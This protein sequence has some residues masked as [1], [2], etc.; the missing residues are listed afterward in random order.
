MPDQPFSEFDHAIIL[1]RS[2]EHGREGL[3]R[4]GFRPTPPGLHGAGLGTANV[5]VMMP[6]RRTYFEALSVVAPT[7]RNEHKRHKL[8]ALDDHLYGVAFK[9]DARL[10][11]DLLDRCGLGTGEAFDFSRDVELHD[12]SREAAFSVTQAR[13]DAIEGAWVF[14]CQHHTPDVVWRSDCLDHPNGALAVA[15]LAGTTQNPEATAESWRP[16]VGDA[17]RLDRRGVQIGTR[18]ADIAFLEPRAY[19]ERFGREPPDSGGGARLHTMIVAVR[20]LSQC[21]STLDAGGLDWS[22]DPDGDLVV[23]AV[24]GLGTAFVFTERAEG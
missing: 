24:D 16:L 12:G 14:V 11:A 15:G 22:E 10:S 20:S 19:A 4:L 1:V 2:L 8:E 18:T 17:L 7:P 3:R 23:P 13:D 9:G 6:D 21:R 5:T